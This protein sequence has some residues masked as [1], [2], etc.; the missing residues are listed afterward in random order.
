M[1]M[2]CYPHEQIVISLVLPRA[3]LWVWT[4]ITRQFAEA[5]VALRHWN[6]QWMNVFKCAGIRRSTWLFNS[7]SWHIKSHPICGIGND[8]E[9]VQWKS[10][11]IPFAVQLTLNIDRF[12]CLFVLF[13]EQTLNTKIADLV[14]FEQVLNLNF[15]VPPVQIKQRNELFYLTKLPETIVSTILIFF[16]R[17]LCLLITVHHVSHHI[18]VC[19]DVFFIM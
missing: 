3:V 16:Q 17:R 14:D 12:R 6:I 9:H 19:A 7:I 10:K 18:P 13:S 1:D 2:P 4:I 8:C 5:F 11:W 15:I